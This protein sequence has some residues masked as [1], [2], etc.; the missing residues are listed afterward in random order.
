MGPLITFMSDYG[1]RDEFVGSVKGVVLGLCPTARIIDITHEIAPQAIDEAAWRLATAYRS[2]PPDT[3]H[4][5]VVDPGVGTTRRPIAA[6][7]RHARWVGPDNGLFTLVFDQ[8]GPTSVVA[9]EPRWRLPFGEGGRPH[10]SRFA[11]AFGATFDGRDL[12]APVAARLACGSALESFGPPVDQWTRVSLPARPSV[13]PGRRGGWLEGEIVRIDRFGNL[14]TNVSSAAID[15][16]FPGAPPERLAVLVGGRRLRFSRNYAEAPL[17]TVGV[18]INSV[19]YLELFCPQ[20][21]GVLQTGWKK[22]K[23]VRVVRR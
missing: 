20:G 14:M 19:G 3:I 10:R 8:D 22:G 11:A 5:A 2:F 21:S 17:G 1:G 18:L 16:A 12:F 23:R 15:R 4:L 6:R 7:S 13:R 9:I